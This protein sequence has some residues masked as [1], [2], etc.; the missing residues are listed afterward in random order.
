MS[1][2]GVFS[3]PHQSAIRMDTTAV[4]PASAARPPA[5]S[6][7]S[8]ARQP[9]APAILN[10]S[11]LHRRAHRRSHSDG[12]AEIGAALSNPAVE[13]IAHRLS[14]PTPQDVQQLVS[15]AELPVGA[16]AATEAPQLM[17]PRK[18][19]KPKPPWRKV[20]YEQQPYEDNHVD[21]AFLSMLITNQ[22]V[23]ILEFWEV[24]KVCLHSSCGRR[25][26][27]LRVCAYC[28]IIQGSFAVSLQLNIVVLFNLLFWYSL[29]TCQ[30]KD[31]VQVKCTPPADG[32]TE[33]D[34]AVDCV[35]KPGQPGHC[36]H[37]SNI[38]DAAAPSSEAECHA[39]DPPGEWSPPA[40]GE[41]RCVILSLQ[42]RVCTCG[43]LTHRLI[44]VTLAG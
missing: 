18:L 21:Q 27:V 28:V 8:P 31:P 16:E 6:N 19:P 36:D 7:P 38:G 26:S 41:L 25:L 9:D 15:A 13:E 14:V 17:R 10:S 1:C 42:I 23:V 11:A 5:A 20:L 24:V 32:A 29:D 3:G 2:T 44:P 35:F 30:S 4:V 39:L 33:C 43:A 40:Q 37:R 34:N 12:S 22:D